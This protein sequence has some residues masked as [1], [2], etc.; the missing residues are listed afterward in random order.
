MRRHLTI[1][2]LN[3]ADS[4]ALLVGAENCVRVCAASFLTAAVVDPHK[5][6]IS[7]ASPSFPLRFS[8]LIPAIDALSVYFFRRSGT[9]PPV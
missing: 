5:G 1:S 6:A 4:S 9:T 3:P 2:I 7:L 8:S